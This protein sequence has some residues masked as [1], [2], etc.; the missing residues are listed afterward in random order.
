MDETTT[1]GSRV[2]KFRK[3]RGMSRK[4]LAGSVGHSA[5]WLKSVELGRRQ[6]DRYSTITA[7]AD[8]LEVHVTALL[9]VPHEGGSPEQQ[10]AHMAIPRL[11]RVLLR[12]E[13]PPRAVGAPLA[14]D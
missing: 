11:R 3:A 14:L 6:L 8:A 2:A 5:E 12:S 4:E 9:G 7:L 13:M 10:R 1:I